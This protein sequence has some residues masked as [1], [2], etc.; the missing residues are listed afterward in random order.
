MTKIAMIE[1]PAPNAAGFS[2]GHPQ[3]PATIV[4]DI[5]ISSFGFV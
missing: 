4:W 2:R 3:D 1:T 5:R